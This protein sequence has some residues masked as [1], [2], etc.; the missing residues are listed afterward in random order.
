MAEFQPFDSIFAPAP[1]T[2]RGQATVITA[3]EKNGRL[4]Y[5][6]GRSVVIR[7]IAD[8]LKAELFTE[9]AKDVTIARVSRPVLR[10][11][12]ALVGPGELTLN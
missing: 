1:A 2:T 11:A 8:P 7:S 3:D 12:G 10:A 5:G 6:S 9:H 4:F